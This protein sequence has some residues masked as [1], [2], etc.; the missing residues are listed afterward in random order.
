MHRRSPDIYCVLF[1]STYGAETCWNDTFNQLPVLL[2]SI[3]RLYMTLLYSTINIYQHH[4]KMEI[5]L[6]SSRCCYGLIR[7]TLICRQYS[8]IMLPPGECCVLSCLVTVTLLG[9]AMTSGPMSPMYIPHVSE[10]LSIVELWP[11]YGPTMACPRGF[12]AKA[13]MDLVRLSRASFPPATLDP[14]ISLRWNFQHASQRIST[15]T[16]PGGGKHTSNGQGKSII[17]K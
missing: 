4:F 11:N 7:K 12:Q 3:D 1:G 5:Q 17:R 6:P 10:S 8:P 2:Y 14:R 9:F 16:M 15:G 13:G